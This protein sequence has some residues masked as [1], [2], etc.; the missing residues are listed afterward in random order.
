MAEDSFFDWINMTKNG[1]EYDWKKITPMN[2]ND[3]TWP[4]DYIDEHERL[5]MKKIQIFLI[6]VIFVK[7]THTETSET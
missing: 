6:L 2:M 4:K 7:F 3:G 5:N 1:L